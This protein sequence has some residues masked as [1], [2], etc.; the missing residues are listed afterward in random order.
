M[1]VTLSKPTNVCIYICIHIYID[2]TYISN[3][4]I[5][6]PLSTIPYL[7]NTSPTIHRRGLLDLQ[8][9]GQKSIRRFAKEQLPRGRLLHHPP[10]AKVERK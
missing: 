5:Y 7:L 3:I 10:V 1:N 4:Y 2:Y 9:A 6:T 8:G